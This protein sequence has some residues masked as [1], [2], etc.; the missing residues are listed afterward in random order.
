M[1]RFI[2]LFIFVVFSALSGQNTPIKKNPLQV[3]LNYFITPP[4]QDSVDITIYIKSNLNTFL[5]MKD[6]VNYYFSQRYTVKNS[7]NEK[8]I[9]DSIVFKMPILAFEKKSSH[10]FFK[11]L[12]LR[13]PLKKESFLVE[14]EDKFGDWAKN[15]SLAFDPDKHA[16]DK[17]VFCSNLLFYQPKSDPYYK[18]YFLHNK[19]VLY[20]QFTNTFSLNQQILNCYFEY[21]LKPGIDGSMDFFIEDVLTGDKKHLFQ[22]TIFGENKVRGTSIVIPV[23][24]LDFG[25]YS[26]TASIFTGKDTI[27]VEKPFVLTYP[28]IA[29]YKELEGS[30]KKINALFEGLIYFINYP[31]SKVE[32]IFTV[33]SRNKFIVDLFMSTAVGSPLYMEEFQKRLKFV[34]F[35]T[36]KT[37]KEA[38]NPPDVAQIVL[39]EGIP[40]EYDNLEETAGSYRVVVFQYYS[41][42]RFFVLRYD[43]AQ[44]FWELVHTNVER[45]NRYSMDWERVLRKKAAPDLHD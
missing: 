29:D 24:Q 12:K 18:N 28:R 19:I 17:E 36:H 4:L 1:K 6:T 16:F 13:V 9:N 38:F 8:L 43:G 39:Q 20:P 45:Y 11:I 40:D 30:V 14:I 31:K 7:G 25:I 21:R 27:R 32:E 2:V 15:F 34:E 23:S 44:D 41:P 5:P 35:F 42:R 33:E 3:T 10:D 26:L 37:Y 22:K